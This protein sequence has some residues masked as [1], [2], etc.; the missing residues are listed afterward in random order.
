MC[1]C[2]VGFPIS[3]FFPSSLGPGQPVG[4]T[5]GMRSLWVTQQIGPEYRVSGDVGRL[6]DGRGA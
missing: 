2:G 5:E 6:G 1:G 4:L 3:H